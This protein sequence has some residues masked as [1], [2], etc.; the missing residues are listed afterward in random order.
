V[1]PLVDVSLANAL[2]NLGAVAILGYWLIFGLPNTLKQIND[3]HK[4]IVGQMIISNQTDRDRTYAAMQSLAQA[5]EKLSIGLQLVCKANQ[6]DRAR[7]R[8]SQH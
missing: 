3:A 6:E 7:G 1:V 8:D 2:A 4:D 5:L